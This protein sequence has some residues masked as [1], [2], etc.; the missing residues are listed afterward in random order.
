MIFL[1]C[2]PVIEIL[3]ITFKVQ[4]KNY[5]T[6]VMY[7]DNNISL[8]S[9]LN[10][11]QAVGYTTVSD[12]NEEI[13]LISED[14]IRESLPNITI[15]EDKV[16]TN[17]VT[18]AQAVILTDTGYALVGNQ[19]IVSDTLMETDINGKVYYNLD[20]I[21]YLL[22]NAQLRS[23]TTKELYI[24]ENAKSEKTVDFYSSLDV[25]LGQ[26]YTLKRGN[27]RYYNASNISG[28][29]KLIRK[30]TVIDG[31]DKIPVYFILN[32]SYVVPSLELFENYRLDSF[33]DS[34]NSL[35]KMS[36]IF[37]T[38]PTT[39]ALVDWWDSNY[40]MT[41]SLCNFM[42]GT[43]GV[44]YVKSGYVVPSM[45]VLRTSAIKDNT[46]SSIFTS[47]GFQPDATTKKY[48]ESSIKWW[49]K[50]YGNCMSTDYLNALANQT[51]TIKFYDGKGT[52]KDVSN[53]TYSVVI[54]GTPSY[55]GEVSG[56]GTDVTTFGITPESS[57]N[58]YV[59][60]FIS[61]KATAD[62]TNYFEV[63]PDSNATTEASAPTQQK[64]TTE[65]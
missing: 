30:F 11:T 29:S 51:R 40:G 26:V 1:Y 18:G 63:S 58:N 36:E 48:C 15:V 59:H 42:Y 38:K 25:K 39:T 49:K 50:Y 33:N 37:Y 2:S 28:V 10:V 5:A 21:C 60:I 4:A 45:V 65:K 41:N 9:D 35:A 13:T 20:I 23:L 61:K 12:D 64:I 16:L 44:E 31:D 53:L 17:T 54:N 22:S 24:V 32:L 46:I 7:V 62:E 47:N 52:D 14:T 34:D 43:K 56:S 57:N 6:A 8:D 3:F 27:I 19:I 55:T